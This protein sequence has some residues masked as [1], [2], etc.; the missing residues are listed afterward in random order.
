MS[1]LRG[2]PTDD[3]MIDGFRRLVRDVN[4]DRRHPFSP[5]LEGV[6]AGET[7]V[8]CPAAERYRGYLVS[9]LADAVSF[10]EVA[11]LL[12]NGDLP[13]ADHLAD[14][15]AVL[16]DSGKPDPSLP[17][18]LESV[19]FHIPPVDVMCTAIS[20]LGHLD[21]EPVAG[22]RDV[23]ARRA[24]RLLGQ[25]PAVIGARFRSSHGHTECAQD[26]SADYVANVFRVIT[27]HEP[28][29]L[30]QSALNA[31]LIALAENG[32]DTP[33]FAARIIM[34]SSTDFFSAS[35]A[36]VAALRG[37]RHL[38]GIESMIRLL[39]FTVRRSAPEEWLQHQLA[40]RS[41]WPGFVSQYE[42]LAD[43][44]T[45]LLRSC[46][47]GLAMASHSIELDQAA[48]W[49]ERYLAENHGLKACPEWLAARLF[50]ALGFEPDLILPLIVLA[51]IPGWAAHGLEAA[52]GGLIRPESRYVGPDSRSLS[53]I[54]VVN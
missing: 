19:P 2:T 10:P 17:A 28:S 30:Q 18:W 44:R 36:A 1:E 37:I 24:L 33:T 5:G 9:E 29:A 54:A 20:M 21:P 35:A 7:A 48:R 46:C 38:G 3:G 39:E 22:G 23:I 25:L 40:G 6:I 52:S 50:T 32:F 34:S 16:S 26:S 4:E 15:N 31:C 14:F 8:S 53:S 12:I 47:D 51:R 41:S 27:G 13:D 11:F 43:P 49:M 42:N 45:E